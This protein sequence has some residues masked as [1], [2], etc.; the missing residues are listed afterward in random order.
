MSPGASASVRAAAILLLAGVLLAPALAPG[1]SA[2]AGS[3][4]AQLDALRATIQEATDAYASAYEDYRSAPNASAREA[5][6]EGMVEAGRTVGDAFLA[7]ER[8]HG[9]PSSLNRFMQTE[10]PTRFYQ[11]FERHVV[12]LRALMVQA[13]DGDPATPTD[14]GSQAAGVQKALDRV[15]GCLPDGCEGLLLGAGAQAFVVLL[16]EGFEAVLLVGAMVAYLHKTD[17]P[18]QAKHVYAGV[19]A[20]LGATLAAWIALERLLGAAGGLVGQRVIEGATMLLAAGVLFY[21][22]SWLLGKIEAARWQAFLDGKLRSSLE[23][24][25]AWVLGLLGFLA[26]FREGLET[27]LFVKALTIQSP[28]AW[29]EVALGGLVG[30]GVVLGLYALIR[31]VG[32]QVPLRSFFA[33]TSALLLLLAI[34]FLGLGLFELQEALL[35]PVSPLVGV[36]SLLTEHALAGVLLQDVL[37]FA[38]TLEVAVGQLLLVALIAASAVWTWTRPGPQ[39][40]RN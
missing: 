30:L 31:H 36:S 15:D 2:Q 16:R 26:V 38:P 4:Q 12:L 10:M 35:I 39:A 13:A 19:A 18:R 17:R 6:R 34:R 32:V 9:D 24:D 40:T 21:V 14:V 37:G 11:G 25:R 20:A 7:F 23:A 3:V 5:A 28:G 27:V 29:T 33:A 8:G 1:A 22:G